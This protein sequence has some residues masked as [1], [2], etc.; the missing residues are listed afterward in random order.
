MHHGHVSQS[1]P[2]DRTDFVHS[3]TPDS[4]IVTSPGSTI[5]DMAVE[6]FRSLWTLLDQADWEGM[7][8]LLA[9]GFRATYPATAECFDADGWIRLNSEYPGGPWRAE[10]LDMFG[11]GDR[12]AATVRLT[13]DGGSGE[14][15]V[16]ASFVTV[17][18][19]LVTALTEV[20][21]DAGREP[22]ADR[23]PS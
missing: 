2:D 1:L 5:D 23:R 19:G 22:P 14:T 18:N 4:E 7:A 11:G 8:T 21:A 20:W 17:D 15:F 10:I 3:S 13:D 16:V 6:V 9:P 12:A